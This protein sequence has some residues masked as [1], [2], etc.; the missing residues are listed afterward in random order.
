MRGKQL[1]DVVVR[2]WDERRLVLPLTYFIEKPFENWTRTSAELLG[3][4]F[5]WVDYSFPVEAAR[6][7]VKAIVESSPHWD[8]RFWKVQVTDTSERGMQ[9]R[10][11]ASSADASKSWDLRC[12]IRE[13]LVAYIQ[14]R[15]P[16]CLPR[17]RAQLESPSLDRDA[18]PWR[19]ARPG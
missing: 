3:S 12:E 10:I 17:L 18:R 11:L 19:P 8:G 1:S 5:V 14:H 15:H 2:I 4:V 16:H 6:G 7:A 9:V 13:K